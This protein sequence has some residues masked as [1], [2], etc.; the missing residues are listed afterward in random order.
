MVPPWYSVE[1]EKAL[2]RGV[3]GLHRWVREAN[4]IDGKTMS[5]I[6][7]HDRSC[8]YELIVRGRLEYRFTSIVGEGANVK[9]YLSTDGNVVKVIKDPKNVRKLFVLAWAETLINSYGIP[10]AKVLHVHEEGLY[11][12]QE[13]INSSSLERQYGRPT[14][15]GSNIHI[16]SHI[17]DQ[18]LD[19]FAKAKLL[20]REREVWLD[21]KSANYHHQ[22]GRIINVDYVPRFHDI[23]RYFEDGHGH[24]LTDG[25]FLDK[26][27]HYRIRKARAEKVHRDKSKRCKRR[28][29][30]SK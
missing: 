30:K 27:F 13:Y 8:P 29:K 18:V 19:H 21:L 17:T 24:A 1:I 11:V 3:K 26:F 9:A 15:H 22:D 28:K 23:W 2:K 6:R 10:A 7:T 16:P 25:Q 14:E 4:K 12:E 20:I 5:I